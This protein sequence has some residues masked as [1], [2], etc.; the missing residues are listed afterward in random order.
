VKYHDYVGQSVVRGDL[1]IGVA[2]ISV[3]VCNLCGC[4]RMIIRDLQCSGDRK[5]N[6]QV[7]IIHEQSWYLKGA[8]KG[9]QTK[10]LP[11]TSESVFTKMSPPSLPITQ[12]TLSSHHP[13]TSPPFTYPSPIPIA[14]A[15]CDPLPQHAL[16]R[17]PAHQNIAP[18]APTF[19]DMS[20]R[21][22]V[23]SCCSVPP[24]T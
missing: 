16:P 8:F 2:V 14:A 10:P 20:G 6:G 7:I 5:E 13:R 9:M 15:F 11:H 4:L 19:P 12:D 18:G 1:R 3:L 17:S 22:P 24:T 21:Q 23:A